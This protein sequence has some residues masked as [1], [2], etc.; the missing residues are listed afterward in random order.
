MTSPTEQPQWKLIGGALCLDFVNTV[1]GRVSSGAAQDGLD[2]VDDVLEE[3]LGAYADLV[4][5]A[6]AAGAVEAGEAE[7][8][9]ARAAADPRAA[10]HLVTRAR[11]LRETLYRIF[12]AVVEGWLPRDDDLARLDREARLLHAGETLGWEAG[13]LVRSWR[14][15]DALAHPLW[16]VVRSAVELLSAGPLERVG[17]CPG[18]R[19]GWL[20]LDTS[21]GGRR[22][23]C[24]M[25]DCGNVAKVR[26]HRRQTRRGDGG[27]APS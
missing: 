1:S 17:Q 15:D 18:E 19:C 6:E 13:R 21:R 24:S 23:W 5:W 20:F 25:A 12:K 16:P 2:W 22:R 4:D 14:G 26:R 7:R 9:D 10:T 8:L 3:R 27:R 11:A